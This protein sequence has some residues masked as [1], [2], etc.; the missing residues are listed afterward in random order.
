MGKLKDL[1]NKIFGGIGSTHDC[2]LLL[3]K[4]FEVVPCIVV[5]VVNAEK[6]SS[7]IKTVPVAVGTVVGEYHAMGREIFVDLLCQI[8]P[9][10]NTEIFAVGDMNINSVLVVDFGNFGFNAQ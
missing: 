9:D 6:N 8:F 2:L 10:R 1:P 4:I 3:F 5:A 7:G